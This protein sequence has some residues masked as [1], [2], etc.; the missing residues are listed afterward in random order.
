MAPIE[1]KVRDLRLLYRDAFRYP[2]SE[3]SDRERHAHVREVD[4]PDYPRAKNPNA[5]G[6]DPGARVVIDCK[7]PNQSG[8]DIA[9][10]RP[11][12]GTAR[13]IAW[14]ERNRADAGDRKLAA[15]RI[16]DIRVV[17]QRALG[18]GQVGKP[19]S[20]QLYQRI[21]PIRAGLTGGRASAR[22]D[23]HRECER[24]RDDRALLRS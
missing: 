14:I 20:R 21:I 9:V 5:G 6:I 15:I 23:E 16:R 13:I 10:M 12:S 7:P 2:A 24:D 1:I 3:Q 8:A 4:R 18:R 19:G 22:G 17:K 11:F